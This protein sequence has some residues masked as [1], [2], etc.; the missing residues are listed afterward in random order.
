MRPFALELLC[1]A[2]VS[3]MRAAS[4]V[5]PSCTL[6]W[7]MQARLA[8]ATNLTEALHAAEA[9]DRAGAT[10]CSSLLVGTGGACPVMAMPAGLQLCHNRKHIVAPGRPIHPP[11][12]PPQPKQ[13]APPAP[14]PWPPCT[15]PG[16]VP[17]PACTHGWA[18]WRAA[19]SRAAWRRWRRCRATRA[20]SWA[21]QGPAWL[22]GTPFQ[23]RRTCA[24]GVLALHVCAV[25]AGPTGVTRNQAAIV[26]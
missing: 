5:P 9:L 13:A 10:A 23:V 2:R 15:M 21:T 11:P 18:W 1:S 25:A 26:R 6:F 19:S 7:P 17:T 24:G 16:A 20:S 8:G 22:C 4:T 12:P 14:L 3:L